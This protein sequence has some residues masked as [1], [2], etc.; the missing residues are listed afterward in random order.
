MPGYFRCIQRFKEQL[1]FI[2][3]L[4]KRGVQLEDIPLLS[5][6]ALA[7]PCMVT[8]PRRLEL[9]DIEAILRRRSSL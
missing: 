2:S 4:S 8:N 1:G 9:A 5:R 3:G 6:K 7:D